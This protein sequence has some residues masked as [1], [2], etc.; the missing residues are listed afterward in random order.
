MKILLYDNETSYLSHL[1]LLLTRFGQVK[2]TSP[3]NIITQNSYDLIVLSG[4]HH[5][6][7]TEHPEYYQREIELVK[8]TIKPILG[9]CLGAEIIAYSFGAKLSTLS[10]KQKGLVKLEVI[11]SDGIFGETKHFMAYENHK[12]AIETLS[13]ELRGLAKSETGYEVIK[14][15]TKPIY[16]FQFHPEIFQNVAYG[17]DIFINTVKLLSEQ[18]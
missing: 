5:A 9:V 12:I 17:D 7:I 10:N 6:Y 4:G 16:G 2:V 11:N 8:N 13:K 1:Q 18:D 3:K 15:R 14:H